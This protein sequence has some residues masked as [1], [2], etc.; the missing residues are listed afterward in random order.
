MHTPARPFALAALAL[1]VSSTSTAQ[2]PSAA[3]PAMLEEV[4]VTAQRRDQSLQDVPLSVSAFSAEQLT[5]TGTTTIV[6]L[7]QSA[8]NVTL[9]PS[10]GTNSTL[11]AFIRGVGQ[12]DPLWGFE[13]G[14]GLYLDDVY[15]ARPQG[16]VLDVYDVERVE[17]LRGPQGTLYGKNTIGGA[18]KYVTRRLDGETDLNLSARVGSYQQRDLLGS[19]DIALTDT[20]FIGAALA[21]FKGDGYGEL[22]TFDAPNY[23][24]EVLSG[25]LS[26]EW[27]P[28][29]ALFLR[30]QYDRSN[31]KSNAKGGHRMTVGAISGAPILDDVYD[32][33][34]GLNPATEVNT[35]GAALT[36]D[37]SASDAWTVK[38]ITAYR[39]GD[40]VGPI[41]F[42][43]L[44]VNDFDVPASVN[45]HQFSQEVQLLYSGD[46]LQMVSGLY[47]FTGGSGG[48]F[49][50][51]L[52]QTVPGA[53]IGL[54][55]PWIPLIQTT[56]GDA[57]TESYSAFVDAD[58]SFG[59][60]WSMTLGGRYTEDRKE[61]VVFSEQYGNFSGD[62]D[63]PFR[64]PVA[65]L[66]DY[67][68][69]RTFSEF[70]PRT[71]VRYS[72]DSGTMLYASY[73]EGFKSGGFDMRGNQAANPDTVEGFEPET[74]D[75]WE[76]GMKGEFLERR[77]RLNAAAFY[78]S[79]KDMQVV[80]AVGFA[81]NALGF[82]VPVQNVENVGEA[83]LR[84]VE[85]ESEAQ[86]GDSLRL[87]ANIGYIDT[88][89]DEWLSADPS[90]QIVDVADQRDIQN[91]PRW[92]GQVG[93]N[94]DFELG[95]Y[96]LLTGSLSLAYR[97]AVQM[98]ETPSAIDEDGYTLWN[99]SLLWY[100][101]D[102]QWSVGVHGRNLGDQEYRVAGYN[103]P[104][105]G[106][107]EVIG[108]YGAPRTVSLQLD[109]RF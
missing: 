74:V 83:T 98:F 88:D 37:F 62:P 54:P 85:L 93:L 20:L 92:T 78:A 104:T 94:R 73:S 3:A 50:A 8:P 103:F 35:E 108:Y 2:T 48:R 65:V 5:Q 10:R 12:Q 81:N 14:V 22:L 19:G 31:D 32:S 34:A 9:A 1:A 15:I 105:T 91:T 101:A 17:I 66:S 96:G 77:L 7:Q 33:R 47:Y 28:S 71:S 70:S 95:S 64:I 109:Y 79:Y 97:S 100:S 106:E 26:L 53:L 58:Y 43:N 72:F 44:E 61:A 45:D 82:P 25:R 11:T 90:G 24:K 99:A 87:S 60:H 40:S 76:V 29:D 13:P 46:N 59:E 49:D 6:D 52:G 89:I 80:T 38:S 30:L 36:A 55:I 23:D 4:I 69:S 107:G 27:Q 86:L 102:E 51:I 84:G 16:A 41:D 63:D 39:E 21:S 42:D 75:S 68:N 18:V 67:E 56:Y 57:D